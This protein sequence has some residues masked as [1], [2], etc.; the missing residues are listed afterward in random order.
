MQIGNPWLAEMMFKIKK[1][2]RICIR[3]VKATLNLCDNQ[4]RRNKYILKI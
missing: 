3:I 2:N 1:I 4:H